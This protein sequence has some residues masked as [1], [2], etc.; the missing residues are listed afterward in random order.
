LKSKKT[1]REKNPKR[2][3]DHEEKWRKTIEIWKNFVGLLIL[4]LTTAIIAWDA[5]LLF[6]IL[7]ILLGALIITSVF[8]LA[9]YYILLK[10]LHF[11]NTFING[12]NKSARLLKREV[13]ENAA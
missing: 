12:Y 1:L 11:I 6:W 7:G 13:K 3:R 8:V 10:N 2:G 5:N 4:G 9:M